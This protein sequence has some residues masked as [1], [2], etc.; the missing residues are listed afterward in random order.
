MVVNAPIRFEEKDPVNFFKRHGWHICENIHF[1]DEG[2]HI[3][4]K[5]PLT[6]PW[7]LLI[8]IPP[9]RKAA[10]KTLDYAM[11]RRI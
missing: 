8:S 2:K 11:F 4:R 6:F 10:N 5:F 3:D 1:L 7:N 9:I